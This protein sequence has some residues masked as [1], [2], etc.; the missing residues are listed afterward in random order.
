M[1]CSSTFRHARGIISR[2]PLAVMTGAFFAAADSLNPRMEKPATIGEVHSLAKF[3]LG[4]Y[5]VAM[6]NPMILKI[7]G[8][9]GGYPIFP[10]RKPELAVLSQRRANFIFARNP[11]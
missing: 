6:L 8:G 1:L 7:E 2:E 10:V 3:W 9:G 11:Q 5:I 4:R